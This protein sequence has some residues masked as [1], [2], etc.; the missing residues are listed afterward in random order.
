MFPC[1]ISPF[2]PHENQPDVFLTEAFVEPVWVQKKLRLR[3][4]E[5]NSTKAL[6]F[7]GFEGMTK[8]FSIL[9]I[10]RN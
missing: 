1:K 5:V 8:L 2:G 4:I 10:C 7:P 3:A 9:E 6:L